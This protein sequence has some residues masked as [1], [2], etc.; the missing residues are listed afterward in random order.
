MA[1]TVQV[2]KRPFTHI[3]HLF[4]LFFAQS[5]ARIRAAVARGM[6]L[7]AMGCSLM[8]GHTCEMLAVMYLQR[9]PPI[10]ENES[11]THRTHRTHRWGLAKCSCGTLLPQTFA[12]G[13]HLAP[14][15]NGS[16]SG[17]LRLLREPLCMY[18]QRAFYVNTR[19]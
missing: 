6:A 17:A 18:A 11:T 1:E 5:R 10:A 3:E 4:G 9:G 7:R 15:F 8:L 12:A 14:G 16:H 19:T 2:H 13:E